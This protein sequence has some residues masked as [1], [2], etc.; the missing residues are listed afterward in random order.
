MPRASRAM[1][2]LL[3][4]CSAAVCPL[5]SLT[6]PLQHH[7]HGIP[8]LRAGLQGCRALWLLQD[9][10]STPEDT[11]IQPEGQPPLLCVELPVSSAP[12]HSTMDVARK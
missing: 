6:H 12:L 9:R 4:S 11:G 1:R 2:A 10:H 8:S 3:I 5:R 7:A